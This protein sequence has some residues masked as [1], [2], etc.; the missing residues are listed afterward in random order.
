[1]K[2]K[3]LILSLIFLL[4]TYVNSNNV[5]KNQDSAVKELYFC[6]SI[7]SKTYTLSIEDAILSFGKWT[8]N[9]YSDEEVPSPKGEIMS[10][11]ENY[12]ICS[13]HQ[14]NQTYGPEGRLVINGNNNAMYIWWDIAYISYE[15]YN[16]S[17]N[18]SLPYKKTNIDKNWIDLKFT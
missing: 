1:M 7:Y 14:K 10:K 11:D 18:P 5:Q 16:C 2:Y 12:I 9:R 8:E 15:R 4:D 13:K 3:I 6:V 17:I